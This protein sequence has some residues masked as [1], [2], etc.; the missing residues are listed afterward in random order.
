VRL[1]SAGSACAGA[2]GF[3]L[4]D[5]IFASVVFAVGALA[6]AGLLIQSSRLASSASEFRTASSRA[7]EAADSLMWSTAPG[8]GSQNFGNGRVRWRPVGRSV[9]IEVWGVDS[10]GSPLLELWASTW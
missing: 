5:V 4:I 1:A 2:Q 10:L 8:P 9:H 3:V 7:E 6:A